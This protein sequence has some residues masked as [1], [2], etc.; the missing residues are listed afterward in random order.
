MYSDVRKCFLKGSNM[1]SPTAFCA[2]TTTMANLESLEIHTQAESV[3]DKQLFL[4]WVT[5]TEDP[6]RLSLASGSAN[7]S[8][9]SGVAPGQCV[10]CVAHAVCICKCVCINNGW[11]G[12]EESSHTSC[13]CQS[14]W[15]DWAR[16][17]QSQSERC[18]TRD[19]RFG[20]ET[21]VWARETE[22]TAILRQKNDE[23]K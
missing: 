20:E 4:V 3:C 1:H 9:K 5:S 15:R 23:R 18:C 14:K 12:L 19:G 21:E 8:L 6:L 7:W 10:L 16:P 17:K 22:M 11:Q 2:Q 13:S